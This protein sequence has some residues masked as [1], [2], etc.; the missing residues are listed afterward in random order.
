MNAFTLGK[1]QKK[2]GRV[3]IITLLVWLVLFGNTT[4][5]GQNGVDTEI[6]RSLATAK[7]AEKLG[8]YQDALNEYLKL[9][10]S[11]VQFDGQIAYLQKV[12][13]K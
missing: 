7:A 6:K 12:R 13:Y 4:V 9:G 3:T 1:K 10:A 11:S 2:I 8:E 5:F